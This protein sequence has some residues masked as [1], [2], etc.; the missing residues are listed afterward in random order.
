MTRWVYSLFMWLLQ[1]ALRI[2]LNRR[3]KA[4]P[5][6]SE[7]IDERFGFY[8]APPEPVKGSAER[9]ALV[10]VHAV[11]L[12]ETRAVAVLID[13][14]RLLLPGM[15]LLLTHGTATGRAQGRSL[16]REGDLQVWQPW[17]S[18][19]AARRFL[20]HFK[21]RIGLLME[22]EIWPN[23]VHACQQSSVP[24]CLVN[25]RLSEKSLRQSLRLSW[26]ARPAYQALTAVWA[27]APQDGERL[28]QLGAPVKGVLGNL[29]FDAAPN[30]D[31]VAKGRSWRAAVG[32]SIIVFAN[33]RE[34]E[35]DLFL[36]AL[37]RFRDSRR[38]GFAQAATENVA[39]R[40]QWMLVPRHPQ[41]FDEVAR[42]CQAAGFTIARR[43][44]W[45]DAPHTADILLGDSLGEM[46][47]YYAMSDV[48]LLGGSFA[49]LGGH[50]LI[51]ATA[52]DCPVVMGPHT[53]NFALAASLAQSAG[54]AFR[55]SDMRSA[56]DAALALVEHSAELRSARSAAQAFSQSHR[57]AAKR[58]AR[59]VVNLLLR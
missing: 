38:M 23:L 24:L 18:A 8:Q 42:Q 13:E 7:A 33:S 16:L 3:A 50:N 48:A 49:N 47:A 39:L 29:K 4:E 27:Q 1:P 58:T 32:A 55:V 11:S 5:G 19:G 15:R 35:E 52:C 17:D 59:A 46:A 2:K 10:W 53:F 26:M 41:R 57:G 14:L 12:G 56:V 45:T 37:Q 22:T 25:A 6:Y 44:E 28:T 40:I 20:A 36:Q 51:E 31:L 30:E 43:S 9:P 54:A 34:G 21:P